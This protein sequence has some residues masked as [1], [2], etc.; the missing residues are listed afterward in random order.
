MS[1]QTGQ[2]DITY[3][4][5]ARRT[6]TFA[7][8]L[9]SLGI[10][11]GQRVF[12]LV[13]RVPAL[14]VAIPGTLKAGSVFAPL[15]SAFGPEPVKQRVVIGSGVAMVTS[16]ALYRKR[17][18]G[19]RRM[20]NFAVNPLV[21]EAG[22]RCLDIPGA[23]HLTELLA[24]QSDGSTLRNFRRRDMALLHFAV[25][26]PGPQSRGRSRSCRGALRH[27]PLRTRSPWGVCWC[28]DPAAVTRRRTGDLA[29]FHPW[30][31]D[32]RRRGEFDMY[33]VVPRGRTTRRCLVHR[34]RP[35]SRA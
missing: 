20:P 10:E 14:Y 32:D 2:T 9:R 21:D 22:L 5:L 3:A 15:F 7:N 34:S 35:R 25:A 30:A 1:G 28:A 19:P 16:A 23:I 29:R 17:S 13:G 26:R 18:A 31:D 6:N 33:R 27:W 12:S 24:E 8:A 11:Q 4:E